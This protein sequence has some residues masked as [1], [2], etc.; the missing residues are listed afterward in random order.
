MILFY[1]IAT[2]LA[3]YAYREWKGLAEDCAGG[4]INGTEGRNFLYYAVIAKREDD[5]IEEKKET[6]E[7]KR[8]FAAKRARAP[9]AAPEAGD[10]MAPLMENVDMEMGAAAGE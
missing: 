6:E 7:K 3:H 9:E 1:I 8:A 2:L 4:S 5:A 10:D